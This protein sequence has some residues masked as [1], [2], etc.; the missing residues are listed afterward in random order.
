MNLEGG[1]AGPKHIGRRVTELQSRRKCLQKNIA[2]PRN[3]FCHLTPHPRNIEA[4]VP[5]NENG[6]T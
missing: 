3:K 5:T 6:R 2:H 4:H 1:L